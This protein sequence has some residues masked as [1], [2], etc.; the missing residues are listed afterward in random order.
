M[1]PED[2]Q[3]PHLTSVGEHCLLHVPEIVL[4]DIGSFKG[5][6]DGDPA[7]GATNGL[8]ELPRNRPLLDVFHEP[9][10]C[11]SAEVSEPE[12]YF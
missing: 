4:P 9:V 3:I 5:R 11:P 10:L 7:C 6:G 2:F 8:L 1:P 12:G